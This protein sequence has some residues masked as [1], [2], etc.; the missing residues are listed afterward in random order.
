I[1]PFSSQD[2]ADYASKHVESA[3]LD[4]VTSLLAQLP[5]NSA[6]LARLAQ[7]HSEMDSKDLPLARDDAEYVLQQAARYSTGRLLEDQCRGVA[8]V[9]LGAF[10]MALPLLSR[11]IAA[12]EHDSAHEK[13][14]QLLLL[15]RA[16]AFEGIGRYS[17]S[18]ADRNR[19]TEVRLR[20]L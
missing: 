10:G 14:L 19:A 5:R 1:S 13:Q 9:N 4:E 3:A 8:L 20:T 2:V 15:A 6:L 18:L 11:A 7:L 17:E 12:C 16:R